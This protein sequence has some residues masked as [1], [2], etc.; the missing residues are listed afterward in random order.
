MSVIFGPGVGPRPSNSP[1][2]ILPDTTPSDQLPVVVQV[3]SG[4]TG[5][6]LEIRDP[7][8]A[9]LTAWDVTGNPTGGGASPAGAVILAPDTPTRN[10]VQ[11]T[12]DAPDLTLRPFSD[13]Q[14]S[15]VFSTQNVAGT[16]DLIRITAAGELFQFDSNGTAVTT[17]SPTAGFS[18]TPGSD[19]VFAFSV[20]PWSNAS[21]DTV[22]IFNGSLARVLQITA[23]GDIGF[24]AAPPAGQQTNGTAADLAAIADPAAKAFLTALSTALVNLGLL[25]APA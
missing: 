2:D 15:P 21:N 5:N 8:G 12:A 16:T 13:V 24:F 7:V 11:A 10:L 22:S 1:P 23:A 3:I 18:V 17:I 9:V 20:T 4:Q 6:A 25:A 19:S 14:V